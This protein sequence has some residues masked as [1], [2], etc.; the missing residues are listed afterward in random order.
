MYV[1]LVVQMI[2][3]TC[4]SACKEQCTVQHYMYISMYSIYFVKPFAVHAC[5]CRTI[6]LCLIL[7]AGLLK[8][9]LECLIAREFYWCNK[10]TCT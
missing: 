8:I 2:I 6:M 7:Y 10:F 3:F 4:H 5:S 9:L 1:L